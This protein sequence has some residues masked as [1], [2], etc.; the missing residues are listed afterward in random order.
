MP[1]SMTTYHVGNSSRAATASIIFS[2]YSPGINGEIKIT[3]VS[4]K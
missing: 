1:K 3:E 4:P 2:W